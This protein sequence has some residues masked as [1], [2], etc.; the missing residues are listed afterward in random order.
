MLALAEDIVPDVYRDKMAAELR[1]HYTVET[2]H[3]L[4]T[5]IVLTPVLIS[6]LTDHG[7]RD[8]AYRIMTAKT[9]PS[10][11]SLMEGDTTFSE[12]WSKKWPDY[13]FGEPGNSRLV[14]GG[15]DLSHCHPMY[16]SVAAWLYERVA[17]L[18]LSELYQRTVHI[19]PYFMECLEWAKANK[20][21][22]FGEV[23]VEWSSVGGKYT[24]QVSIPQG[25][26]ARCRFPAGCRYLQNTETAQIYHPDQLGYFDFTLGGG[27]WKLTN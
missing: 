26:S 1:R 7:F 14:K 13:Y 21:T 20:K 11:F 2:D 16:G 9:Y 18:D 25:L 8:I 10:Y 3:H 4:D 23:S 27:C 24:L 19:K 6:Y 5:G 17:G 22:A 15:G 12:H